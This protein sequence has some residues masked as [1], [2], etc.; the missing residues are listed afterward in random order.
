M[1]GLAGALYAYTFCSVFPDAFGFPLILYGMTILTFGGMYTMWG[2]IIAA[3]VLWG[4]SQILPGKLQAF[5]VIIY[6]ALLIVMLLLRPTGIVDRGAT[7]AIARGAKV[8]LQ[9]VKGSS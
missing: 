9:R 2:I 3:P 7:R 4:I 8:L 6:G 1:G 5:A